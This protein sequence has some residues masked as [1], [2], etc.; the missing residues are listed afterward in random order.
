MAATT[1]RARRPQREPQAN[2]RGPDGDRAAP[3]AP[4][5]EVP[6]P[7]HVA[8]PLDVLLTDAALGPLRRWMPGRAGIKAAAKL[9]LRPDRVAVRG[10]RLATELGKVVAGRSDVAPDKRDRRFKDPAWSGNFAFRRLMQAYLATGRTV[11]GLIDDA[12]LDWASERRVRFAAENVL[13]AIAPSNVPLTNPSALKAVVDTGGRNFVRGGRNFVR[14][15]SRPPRIPSMVDRS[16]FTVGENVAASPGA[17]V[18]RTP[19]FELLQY[20]PATAR[21][22]E[23]PLLVV[24]PMI[25]KYYVADLAPGRSMVEHA[26][27]QGQQAFAVS[28]R[29]PDRRHAEWDLDTYAG[30]VVE[31]LGAVEAI[32]GT[33]RSH[34]LGL[35]AGGIV[36][37]TVVSVLAA[38]GEQDRIA[39]LS[40]GV[41]VLDQRQAG[42]AGAFM[43]EATARLAIADSAR[44]GYL[45]GRALAGVFAWL[46]PNDLVW[47]YW[48][49][50]YLLGKDPPA[51]DILFWN[52]D[53]TNM[54]AG[55]H[56]DFVRLALRNALVHPGEA[57]VLGTPVDLSRI[58]VDSYLVAGIADHITP[59]T[60]CYR[61]VQLLGSRPR[62]VL[63]TSGHIAAMVNPPGN[64]KASFRVNDD[65]P[66]DPD[67]FLAGAT[68]HPGSWWEDWT[69]WLAE[70]SGAEHDAPHDLGSAAHPPLEAAPGTYVRE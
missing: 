25:N 9:G 49:S 40:L 6:E 24:P 35:C 1:R 60:S 34:V 19:V 44:R 32:T 67:A 36:L 59:W 28:W 15:M 16:A 38:R 48:V 56:R 58:T 37:S 43:D 39:G 20:R 55:L 70:R 13:D 47:N 54:P 3:P 8:E 69:A 62:F 46:R 51:F 22:R 21:V 17:V 66:D 7:E 64:D 11:D 27:G 50:N 63:S 5:G 41:C 65:L 53:T 52:A 23:T 30:A 45:D 18:L 68:M 14:D 31:A 2:G 4:E 42:T 26:V 33:D 29:N 10:V 57:E 12:H 61:S